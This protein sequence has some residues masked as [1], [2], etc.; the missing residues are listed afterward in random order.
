MYKYFAFISYNSKDAEWGK[1]CTT[2][3]IFVL[4]SK[5]NIP[6]FVLFVKQIIVTLQANIKI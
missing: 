4:C 6:K 1:A 2:E 3:A 5:Q